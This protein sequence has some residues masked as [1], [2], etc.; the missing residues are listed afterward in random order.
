MEAK[1]IEGLMATTDSDIDHYMKEGYDKEQP[2]LAAFDYFSKLQL[3]LGVEEIK[4]L[5]V[6]N[7]KRPKKDESDWI[8][9]HMKY[10]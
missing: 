9:I 7:I 6:M 3:K 5:G 1:K 4:E 8:Y 10:E 2:M